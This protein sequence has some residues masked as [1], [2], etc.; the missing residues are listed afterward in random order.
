[1]TLTRT[2]VLIVFWLLTT[3]VLAATSEVRRFEVDGIALNYV[4][5][6]EGTPVVLVHGY[7]SAGDSW[8]NN[9]V[10]AT[11]AEHHRVLVL[12]A[13]GHGRSDKPHDVDAYGTKMAADL[14][15]LLDHEGI[16]RAHLVGYLDG[17]SAGT[18]GHHAGT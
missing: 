1:M 15:A 5:M 18:E 3:S 16:E 9:G 2:A 11:L 6:G 4:A 17:R 7:T 14:V 13:R 8:L 10:A 12:D